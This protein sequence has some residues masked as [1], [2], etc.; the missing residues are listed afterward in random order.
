MKSYIQD[1]CGDE[2]PI[3]IDV[4]ILQCLLQDAIFEKLVGNIG[5]PIGDKTHD[6]I[7]GFLR[8]SC[9]PDKEYDE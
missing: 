9:R 3:D 2:N 7:W 5:V 8:Q 1:L 6:V 4:A